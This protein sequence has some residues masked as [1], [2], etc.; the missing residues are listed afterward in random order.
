MRKLVHFMHCSL[1]GFVAGPNGEMEW[2]KIDDEMFEHALQRTE[3]ADAGLYGRVTYDM[4]EAYWPTAGAQP[5]ASKHDIDHSKWYNSVEKVVISK[6]MQGQ[7]L[8]NTTIISDHVFDKIR[9]LK[10]KPGKEIVM[11]GS[12]GTAQSLMNEDLIDDIWLFINP[13]LLGQGIPLFANLK[14][15]KKLKLLSS[16]MLPSGVVVLHY[17]RVSE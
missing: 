15:R 6:T 3:N 11:F 9:V 1:D 10:N 13:I 17:E 8:D 14:A 2:I 16:E 12:P 7:L 5:N 4:M